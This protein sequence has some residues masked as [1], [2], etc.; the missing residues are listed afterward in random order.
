MKGKDA[1]KI[2]LYMMRKHDPQSNFK[3]KGL[4][5]MPKWDFMF[6]DPYVLF[7]ALA[8]CKPWLDQCHHAVYSI[9]NA[10]ATSPNQ[11]S[12]A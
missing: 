4:S 1:A 10:Q 9:I 12:A 7:M 2:V 5:D 8:L 11:P 3:V 6:K